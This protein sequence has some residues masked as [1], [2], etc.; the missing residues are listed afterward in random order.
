MVHDLRYSC[1]TIVLEVKSG[2][3]HL[4]PTWHGNFGVFPK[5]TEGKNWAPSLKKD[6]TLRLFM[7]VG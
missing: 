3:A 5:R 4:K 7:D 6:L 1:Q 2:Q